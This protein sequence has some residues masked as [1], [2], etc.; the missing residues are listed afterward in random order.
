MDQRTN[1]MPLLASVGIGAVAYQMLK[2]NNRMT[3]AVRQRMGQMWRQKELFPN[4]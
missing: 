1:W 4:R 2:P 3:N